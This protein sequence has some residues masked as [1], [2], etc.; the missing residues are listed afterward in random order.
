MITNKIAKVRKGFYKYQG[1][2]LYLDSKTM[3][4]IDTFKQTRQS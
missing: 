2:E 4:I 3:E 1:K